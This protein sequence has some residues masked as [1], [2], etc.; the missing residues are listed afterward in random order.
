MVLKSLNISITT[1]AWP[2]RGLVKG[3]V[4]VHRAKGHEETVHVRQVSRDLLGPF[5]NAR[6]T[7]EGMLEID[8]LSSLE[9]TKKVRS[10]GG[11]NLQ[12][13]MENQES[14]LIYSS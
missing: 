5:F 4:K 12:S 2:V 14:K 7:L 10:L 11:V 6:G 8:V 3:L 1:S 13:L 9:K